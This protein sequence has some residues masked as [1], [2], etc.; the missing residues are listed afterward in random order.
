VLL[1]SLAFSEA[2]AIWLPGKCESVLISELE[3]GEWI[4]WF[5]NDGSD[6]EVGR[7]KELRDETVIID[8]RRTTDL[9][10][11]K[12]S[13]IYRP[14]FVQR[15]TLEYQTE[16][17]VRRAERL[18]A[19]IE[20]NGGAAR[21]NPADRTIVFL[22]KAPRAGTFPNRYLLSNSVFS[23]PELID[24]VIERVHGLGGEFRYQWPNLFGT[25]SGLVMLEYGENEERRLTFA[26]NPYATPATLA[27]ETVHLFDF[28]VEPLPEI[29]ELRREATR[30]PQ[31]AE[32]VCR[33]KAMYLRLRGIIES[34]GH[35]LGDRPVTLANSRLDPEGLFTR[36]YYFKNRQ[37]FHR[38]TYLLDP[39]AANWKRWA[40]SVVR[41]QSIRLTPWAVLAGE[42]GLLY[43]TR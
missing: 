5:E 12:E 22:D 40:G 4:F 10:E 38:G 30:S 32:D 14:N 29:E 28:M 7:V 16:R 26:L 21:L 17:P 8:P 36:I 9:Y 20:A 11:A 42:I 25:N 34:R 41:Y 13:E 35:L 43:Y 6:F 23:N 39:T 15:R 1:G 2:H 37:M 19:K 18:L 27:H 3:V 33:L 31:T 24:Q